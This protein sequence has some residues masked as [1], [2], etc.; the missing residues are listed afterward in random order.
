MAHVPQQLLTRPQSS[1][2]GESIEIRQRHMEH[3][4]FVFHPDLV[5]CLQEIK[6][7]ARRAFGSGKGLALMILSP[8]GGGKTHLVKLLKKLLPDE[9]LETVTRVRVASFSVPPAPS[10]ASMPKACLLGMGDPTWNVGNAGKAMERLL[11]LLQETDTRIIIIDNVHDIP[12]RR[13][14]KGIQQVGNWIRD[15]IEKSKLLVV[16]LGTPAAEE[17]VLANPQLRRR[18][19]AKLWMNYFDLSGEGF[20]RLKRFLDEVDKLLPLAELS[21]LK[22]FT[23]EIYYASNGIPDYIFQILTEAVDLA[24]SAGRE[25]I[26]NEDLVG[27]FTLTLLDSA[28]RRLNPFLEG[29]PSRRLD[30]YGEPFHNWYTA[31]NPN[32]EETQSDSA[33]GSSANHSKRKRKLVKETLLESVS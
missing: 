33:D 29:G 18:N 3:D 4:M 13:G 16:L 10:P 14:K 9:D 25:R 19:P 7:R 5:S 28:H 23:K 21:D 26:L 6:R 8:S 30:Q 12:E 20:A 32:S 1:W 11:S 2:R 22:K 24:V 27:A 17:I 15:L 31:S